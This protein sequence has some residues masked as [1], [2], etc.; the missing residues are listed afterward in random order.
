MYPS[1]I[2]SPYPACASY[3]RTKTI[4]VLDSKFGDD[5]RAAKYAR[6]R[7]RIQGHPLYIPILCAYRAFERIELLIK[8]LTR[9]CCGWQWRITRSNCLSSERI[10]LAFP[11][12]SPFL[13]EK[14]SVVALT[15]TY[16]SSTQTLYCSF[17]LLWNL[18]MRFSGGRES[19]RRSVINNDAYLGTY[20]WIWPYG[21]MK[22]LFSRGEYFERRL[23]KYL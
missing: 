9:A 13:I 20:H 6:T 17:G 23:R 14:M 10:F 16:N 18:Y 2:T 15:P 3:R 5:T 12:P 8:Y 11:P 22:L 7:V 21:M 19:R 4:C 1:T